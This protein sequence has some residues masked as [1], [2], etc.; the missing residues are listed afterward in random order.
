MNVVALLNQ[1]LSNLITSCVDLASYPG[2][3][4][5]EPGYKASVDY[6]YSEHSFHLSPETR[7]WRENSR[8]NPM[9]VCSQD[10]TILQNLRSKHEAFALSTPPTVSREQL[11]N[12][13]QK[14]AKK[15]K[16]LFNYPMY[17]KIWVWQSKICIMSIA[18]IIFKVGVASLTVHSTGKD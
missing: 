11:E 4:L 14:N 12:F 6:S 3:F 10:S 2:P 15:K 13:Y 8:E 16:S 9:C 17:I 5:N 1:Q 7:T 18:H